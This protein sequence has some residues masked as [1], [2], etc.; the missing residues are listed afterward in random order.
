MKTRTIIEDV[1][2]SLN[3]RYFAEVECGEDFQL[4]REGNTP[5]LAARALVY[6][7]RQRADDAERKFIESGA[8]THPADPSEVSRRRFREVAAQL[9]QDLGAIFP[10]PKSMHDALALLEQLAAGG[11]VVE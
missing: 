10:F 7:L 3:R 9:R 1:D 6:A 2:G 4:R 8:M 5:E 11:K